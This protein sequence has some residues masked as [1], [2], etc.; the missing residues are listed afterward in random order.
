VLKRVHDWSESNVEGGFA[1]DVKWRRADGRHLGEVVP[2]ERMERIVDV[3][4]RTSDVETAHRFVTGILVGMDVK[5]GSFRLTDPSGEDYRGVLGPDFPRGELFTV[6][7]LYD[8]HIV[9]SRII[10]YATETIDRKFSLVSLRIP[11]EPSL[12]IDHS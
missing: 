1:A 2:R 9:E 7:R 10:R 11:A 5:S 6:N 8:A 3:I 4:R 12:P